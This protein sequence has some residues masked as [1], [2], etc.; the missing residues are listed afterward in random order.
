MGVCL[1]TPLW[2]ES[3]QIRAACALGGHL[4]GV[5]VAMPRKRTPAEEYI[6]LCGRYTLRDGT[7]A[8][9]HTSNNTAARRYETASRILCSHDVTFCALVRTYEEANARTPCGMK[10]RTEIWPRIVALVWDAV[11]KWVR[12][13]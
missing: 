8:P 10:T 3:T 4:P 13:S 11:D 9:Q 5:M 2:A 12:C 1:M 7:I 6:A